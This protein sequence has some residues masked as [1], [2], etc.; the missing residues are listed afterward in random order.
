MRETFRTV[1]STMYMIFT[2]MG[3]VGVVAMLGGWTPPLSTVAT[4]AF[5]ALMFSSSLKFWQSLEEEDE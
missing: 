4:C 5:V 2:L 3:A 1:V